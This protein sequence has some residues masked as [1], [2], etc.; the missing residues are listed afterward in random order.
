MAHKY[1]LYGI[2]NKRSKKE[3]EDFLKE[4]SKHIQNLERKWTSKSKNPKSYQ[5]KLTQR[6][7]Y[8]ASLWSIVNVK[9]LRNKRDVSYKG[10]CILLELIFYW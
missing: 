10:Y 3:L 9:F 5:I 1:I 8:Q 7:L 4:V 6:N 2:S